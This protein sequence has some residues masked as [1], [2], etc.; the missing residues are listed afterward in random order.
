MAFSLV[1]ALQA[2]E[3]TRVMRPSADTVA[4]AEAEALQEPAPAQ[5][6]QATR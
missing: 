2:A 1:E 6:G 5:T 3:P 4:F